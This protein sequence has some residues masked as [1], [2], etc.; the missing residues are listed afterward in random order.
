MA[1]LQE[2][3]FARRSTRCRDGGG[4]E[5]GDAGEVAVGALRL[6]NRE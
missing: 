3:G 2:K 1:G 5:K 4:R 6:C